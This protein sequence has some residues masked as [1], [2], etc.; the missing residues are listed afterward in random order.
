MQT[1]EDAGVFAADEL[2]D[3][4]VFAFDEDDDGVVRDELAEAEGDE[5]EGFV[6]RQ[7]VAEIL[8]EFEEGV[9]FLAGGGDGG[10]EVGVV[11]IAAEAV[12]LQAGGGALTFG[13]GVAEAQGIFAG[14]LNFSTLP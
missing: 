13:N 10:K 5:G 9:G 11:D 1:G 7:G 14:L 4:G 12:G 6:E 8:A 3:E 2:R